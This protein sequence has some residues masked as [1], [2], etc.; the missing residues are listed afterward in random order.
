MRASEYRRQ[1]AQSMSEKQFQE[2]V[3]A[4]AHRLGWL[5]YHPFDSRR[6]APGFPDLVLVRERT[7]FRELKSAT[8]VLSPP[9]RTWLAALRTSGADA[10][11]W[12]PEH[13]MSGVIERE[14]RGRG[15]K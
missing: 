11:V 2:H 9:Q 6:S 7:L 14:L 8:G 15:T 1:F 3:I 12:K 4:L 13:L 10:D 5:V